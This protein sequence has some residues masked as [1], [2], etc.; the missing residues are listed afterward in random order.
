MKE[1]VLNAEDKASLSL[2]KN[3]EILGIKRE[4]AKNSM[5]KEQTCMVIIH[6][7]MHE[8]YLHNNSMI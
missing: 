5:S 6:S 7:R 1:Y 8:N 3:A 4:T 2:L